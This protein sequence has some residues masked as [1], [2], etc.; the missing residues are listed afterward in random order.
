MKFEQLYQQIVPKDIS[1]DIFT[2]VGEIYPVITAGTVEHHNSMT[3]S[4]GGMGILFKRPVTWCVFRS[5]RYTLELIRK[6]KSYTL[7]YFSDEYKK[8]VMYLGSK[9]GRDSNKMEKV[10]LTS[11]QTP[12]GNIT[13]KEA[14][15]IIECK[16]MQITTPLLADFY[17]Q[18]ALE[19]LTETYKQPSDIR[20]YVYGEICHVWTKSKIEKSIFALQ[21]N[22]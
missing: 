13:Y 3:A 9:S 8:E 10:E 17:S 6:E 19:W 12:N 11:I 16:L 4:G 15:L 2:L 5:D 18:K 22:N 7:S 21:M 14:E 1:M 20:Q